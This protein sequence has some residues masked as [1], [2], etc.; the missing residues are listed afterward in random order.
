M[1]KIEKDS[2]LLTRGDSCPISF[3]IENYQ[4]VKGDKIDF[5]IYNE[6]ELDK[7]PLLIKNIIFHM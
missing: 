5:K 6:N 3:S 2:I 7:P 1:F 4:F